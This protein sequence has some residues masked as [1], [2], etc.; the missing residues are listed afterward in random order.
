MEGQSGLSES[1]VISWVSAIQG[2]PLSGV[3]LYHLDIVRVCVCIQ[4][5]DFTDKVNFYVMNSVT[6]F[7]SMWPEVRRNASL[8]VGESLG[9]REEGREVGRGRREEGKK[10]RRGRGRREERGEGG[11]KGRR[12]RGKVKFSHFFAWCRA[13]NILILPWQEKSLHIF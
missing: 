7:K 11:K 4:V 2:C 5:Q 12:G 9:C 3:P 1:S 6:F 10:G 13:Q 8:F